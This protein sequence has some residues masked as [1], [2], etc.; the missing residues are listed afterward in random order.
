[1]SSEGRQGHWGTF[2]CP[3]GTYQLK[4]WPSWCIS[5]AVVCS[6][7]LETWGTCEHCTP[8]ERQSAEEMHAQQSVFA[9]C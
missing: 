2:S 5:N 8:S 4:F 7:A 3:Q 1:M 9:S 6:D